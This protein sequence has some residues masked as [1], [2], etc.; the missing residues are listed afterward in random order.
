MNMKNFVLGGI[1]GGVTDFLLGW[2]LYGMI[3][4]D[5]FGGHEPNLNFI[6]FGCLAF[7]F[8][9]SYILIVIGG[10]HGFAAGARYGAAIGLLVALMSNFFMRAMESQV[11]WQQFGVD[12]IIGIIMGTI[13]GG[14]VAAVNK[15]K[16]TA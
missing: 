6:A 10:V 11:N 5:F 12:V 15:P 3:F 1:A 9:M 13:V 7:G 16:A 8:L 4:Y 2:I 14:V